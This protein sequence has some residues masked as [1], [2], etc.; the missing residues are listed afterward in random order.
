VDWIQA[1]LV[2]FD[3]VLGAA[4]VL[5]WSHIQEGKRTAAE[6]KQA[7]TDH[8]VEVAKDY[9]TNHDVQRVHDKLDLIIEKLDRKADK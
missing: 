9:A 6:A 5:L 8:R 4:G 2:L 1:G 3:F 7:V